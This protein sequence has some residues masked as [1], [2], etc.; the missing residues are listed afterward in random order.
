VTT[1]A[2]A[3]EL[4]R[5]A[6]YS[7]NS[8]DRRRPVGG[9]AANRF[10]LHDM[11]GNVWEWCMDEVEEDKQDFTLIHRR[12]LEG[13][14]SHH[15]SSAEEVYTPSCSEYADGR[16]KR[17]G[18][19]GGLHA[20]FPRNPLALR[21][22]CTPSCSEYADGRQKRH[23]PCGGLHATFPRNPLVRVGFLSRLTGDLDVP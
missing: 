10:G 2:W 22:V 18:P 17:H 14:G 20:T 8:D 21:D 1:A 16:Q 12:G 13:Q 4:D 23:G 5:V 9:K 6:W 11:L 7:E 19:C 3:E 15:S